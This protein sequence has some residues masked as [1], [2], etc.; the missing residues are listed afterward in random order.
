MFLY[1]KYLLLKTFIENLNDYLEK[2]FN[3]KQNEIIRYSNYYEFTTK[4]YI[5][6][7]SQRPWNWSTISRKLP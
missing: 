5:S 1:P 2:P 3:Y 6:F 4:G 7:T